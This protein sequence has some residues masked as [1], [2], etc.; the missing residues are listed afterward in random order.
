MASRYWKWK[1]ASA[2]SYLFV[3]HSYHET[4]K[5]RCRRNSLFHARNND[6]RQT[7]HGDFFGASSLTTY[8]W[9]RMRV[10]LFSIIIWI[11]YSLPFTN[12]I[13]RWSGGCIGNYALTVDTYS[14]ISVLHEARLL[15][16][17]DDIVANTTNCFL[18][19]SIDWKIQTI[20]LVFFS[21]PSLRLTL[22]TG[23]EYLIV[24]HVMELVSH[25]V[26]DLHETSITLLLYPRLSLLFRVGMVHRS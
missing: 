19:V 4:Y 13:Y 9:R 22:S 2:P 12:S 10:A 21:T 15:K 8:R 17:N 5:N 1:M 26:I 6:E 18:S 14:F 7:T 23:G 11:L 25:R 20:F 24:T 16:T 3:M